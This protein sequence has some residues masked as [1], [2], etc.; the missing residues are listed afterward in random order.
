MKPQKRTDNFII[1]LKCVSDKNE[2]IEIGKREVTVDKIIMQDEFKAVI[3]IFD[4]NNDNVEVA[5]ITTK[6]VFFL[7][8]ISILFGKKERNRIENKTN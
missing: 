2:K 8:Q 1:V 6:I 3:S 7:A 5:I 4:R